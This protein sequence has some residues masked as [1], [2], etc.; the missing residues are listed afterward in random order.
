MQL[1]MHIFFSE[2][3]LLILFLSR[4]HE[5]SHKTQTL[6]YFS[7]IFVTLFHALKCCK[8]M[9]LVACCQ[10]FVLK[11]IKEYWTP[12]RLLLNPKTYYKYSNCCLFAIVTVSNLLEI[13]LRNEMHRKGWRYFILHAFLLTYFFMIPLSHKYFHFYSWSLLKMH[14]CWNEN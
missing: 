3:F 4:K 10:I 13:S 1:C 11:L 9:L 8:Y 12:L 14:K 7:V 5:Q 6:F 2:G